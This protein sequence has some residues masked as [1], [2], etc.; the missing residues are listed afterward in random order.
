VYNFRTLPLPGQAVTA[1]G[2]IRFLI[3]GDNQIKAEPRYDSLTLN[4]FKKLKKSSEPIQILQIILLLLS[5]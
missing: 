3:M 1:N 2:K 5:W 4:A